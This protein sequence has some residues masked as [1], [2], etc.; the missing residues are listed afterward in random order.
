MD[1]YGNTGDTSSDCDSDDL[2]GTDYTDTEHQVS[3]LKSKPP[4]TEKLVKVG[5]GWKSSV[6]LLDQAENTIQP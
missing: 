5:G 6:K 3:V 2:D 1:Q 4:L